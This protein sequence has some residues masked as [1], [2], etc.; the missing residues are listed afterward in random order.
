MASIR[1]HGDKW[2]V[3]VYRKGVRRSKVVPT[4]TEGKLWASRTV[5]E[6]DAERPG[7]E[8]ARLHFALERYMKEVVPTHKGELF[9]TRRIKKLLREMEDMPLR[10]LTTQ[11][12]AAW[13]DKQTTSPGTVLREMKILNSF[14]E[15]CRKEWGYIQ[16]NPLHD[17]KKPTAPPPRRRGVSQDEIDQVLAN[18]KWVDGSVTTKTQQI[19]CLFLLGIET[20]MRKGEML[21]LTPDRCFLDRR[22]VVLEMTKN[23]DRRQVPLSTRA[24]ELLTMV[25]CQFTVA[26]ATVDTL[27]RRAAPAD[28]HFHDTRSEGITRLAKKLQ[29]LDLARAIG[30]RD[31]KSL[32]LYYAESAEDLAKKLG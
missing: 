30:H 20:A 4:K 14:L 5:L 9:E 29:V 16:T 11:D 12:L 15:R 28:L 6:I 25:G 23:G 31:P 2:F 27:F 24:V 22:Y 8:S 26:P 17:V 32:L 7:S 21:S 3:E 19:A 18:L 13:R 10:K 1:K